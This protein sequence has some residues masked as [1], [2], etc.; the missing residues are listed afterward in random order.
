M[1]DGIVLFYFACLSY[2]FYVVLFCFV[3]VLC[4]V[5]VVCWCCGLCCVFSRVLYVCDSVFFVRSIVVLYCFVCVWCICCLCVDC[6]YLSCVHRVCVL[7]GCFVAG[8]VL[9]F[10]LGLS[11]LC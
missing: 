6:V 10:V 5:V 8:V 3:F 1:S 4:F 2:V 11:C 7:I 9:H